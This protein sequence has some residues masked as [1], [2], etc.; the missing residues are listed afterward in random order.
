M[1]FL[2]NSETVFTT[3]KNANKLRIQLL[4]PQALMALYITSNSYHFLLLS[5]IR[6]FYNK[7]HYC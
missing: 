2:N 3:S 6:N 5:L 7:K 4:T 1:I